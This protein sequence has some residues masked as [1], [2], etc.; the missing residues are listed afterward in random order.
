MLPA[1]PV[2]DDL[3]AA[4]VARCRYELFPGHRFCVDCG[5]RID[6]VTV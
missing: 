1:E 2:G 5:A 3:I 4:E 6:S